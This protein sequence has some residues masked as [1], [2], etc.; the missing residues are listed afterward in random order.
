MMAVHKKITDQ[1][2]F[3]IGSN[4]GPGADRRRAVLAVHVHHVLAERQPGRG[5]R[6]VRESEGLQESHRHG[7]QLP[8]GQ[9]LHRRVQAQL[10]GRGHRR[11]L[12]AAE[13]ARLL[14]RACAG[15]RQE[16]RRCL[17]VLS[18][19]PR[20]QLR[21]AVQAGRARGQ[22][23]AAVDFDHRRIDAAGA[24]DD[25]L[26]V[27]SGTFWG[28]DFNNPASRKF[29]DDFEKKYN[30][31]PSQYAAQSYDAALLLDSAIGKVKGNVADK[32]AFQAA[33]RAADFKSVRGNFKFNNNGF[34]IQDQYIFEVAKD[35]KGRVSLKT[36]ATPLKDH[37]DAYY[38]Q[39][40]L[41]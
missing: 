27:I 9:G 19:R 13:P 31:I 1:E 22:G 14:G 29:V 8:G 40:K 10:Q 17:R 30:R 6:R 39:C 26:G 23:S 5:G 20:R 41:S 35:A 11:D 12:H 37:K 16:S 4:A 36:V 3:V 15:C 33:L 32:K 34:P 2:V 24:E 18:G 7:A 38:T 25:A 21:A 28:P